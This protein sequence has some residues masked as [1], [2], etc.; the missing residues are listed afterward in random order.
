MQVTSVGHA[1]FLIETKAGSI[2]CDR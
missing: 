2:L 1:G